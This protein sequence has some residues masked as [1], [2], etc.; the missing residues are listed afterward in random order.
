M[1]GRNAVGGVHA[2][3]HAA[4]LNQRAASRQT[5]SNDSRRAASSAAAGQRPLAPRQD[6]GR[7]G[8]QQ[9]ALRRTVVLGL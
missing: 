3:F 2:F 6:V 7:V 4:R 5:F 8:A 1:L 9:D